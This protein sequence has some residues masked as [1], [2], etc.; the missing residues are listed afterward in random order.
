MDT[1]TLARIELLHPKLR[2]EA[3]EIYIAIFNAL[4]GRAAVRFTHTLRTIAEQ[5]AL[6]AQ[7][8][9]KP[10]K[11]V[12]N[13]KGGQS[14]HNFGLA[15]FSDDTEILTN[16]GWKLFKD[17]NKSEDV[18]VFKDGSL[19]YEKPISYISNDYNGD[20][21]RVNTRSVDLLVTPNHKMVVKK[22]TNTKWEND[23]N[24]IEASELS[25]MHKIPTA[26]DFKFNT[27]IPDYPFSDT[28][29]PETWWQFMGWHIS[30]GSCCGISDGVKRTH[31]GR[32]KVTI[33]QKEGSVEYDIIKKCLDNT[34]F[35]Y[36]YI[37]HEFIIHSK[38]LH[39]HLFEQGNTYQ[40][41]IPRY[42]LN[43]PKH[44][45][46]I[47]LES[48]ILGDGTH[49]EKRESYWTVN[50]LLAD[51]VAELFIMLGKSCSIGSKE[52]KSHMM[53]GGKELQT[54]NTQY[55]INNRN[56]IT[57]ELRNGSVNKKC[58]SN[59]NY[60]GVVY[61]VTTNAGAVVVKRN[62]KVSISGNCDICLII[63]GKEA[64][65]DT[66]KDY[67]GDKIADW[68]EAVAI[69]KTRGWEWGGDFKSIKDA[70]HFQ[71]TFGF[72]TAKLKT[73]IKGSGYPAP[74]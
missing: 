23:W 2:A 35:H 69:F 25:Y 20:M 67:D 9:T 38:A 30:E 5:D 32:F 18:M 1:I 62:G 42:L 27:E 33:S 60:E 36:N 26:G 13:A 63:D 68:M 40:R 59:E 24:F 21:V 14:Y 6:Y 74:L 58:I 16:E 10:G 65:W 71:K 64:S 41:R 50:K 53:P 55:S 47:L 8:R 3:K 56:G 29:S 49:Y 45:L 73:M 57:Q 22:K 31:N 37:G 61:C 44:L 43:A 46:E 11:K 48:L 28:I 34:G 15:C 54:F 70:P 4:K 66:L 7:G 51:D 17:L 52:P 72:T 19:Y 39:S 12:T